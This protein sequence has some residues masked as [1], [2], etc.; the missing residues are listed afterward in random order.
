MPELGTALEVRG[1][2]MAARA[3]VPGPAA[4]VAPAP[5]APDVSR[6][7]GASLIGLASGEH[8]GVRVVLGCI[9]A[10]SDKWVPGLSSV[11][12][13]RATPIILGAAG[14]HPS[15]ARGPT[16]S[17]SGVAFTEAHRGPDGDR[18]VR[19]AHALAFV[20]PDADAV[21]CSLACSEPGSRGGAGCDAVAA[22]FAISGD[23]HPEPP[24]G[25]L[26]RSIL[27]AADHPVLAVV[28]VSVLALVVVAI[29]LVTRPKLRP[30]SRGRRSRPR[31]RGSRSP[32]SPRTSTR[33]PA[34]A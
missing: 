4:P 23:L 34:G 29:L 24:P 14:L 5:V 3:L 15:L 9:R 12:F 17:M 26:A 6:L 19:V 32:P 16:P 18:D 2:G 20:G 11:V 31:D 33:R 27:G 25:L 21:A 22:S 13:E 7:P 10:P 8:D 30:T 1:D 28:I